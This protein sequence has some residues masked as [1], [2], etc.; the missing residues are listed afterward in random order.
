MPNISIERLREIRELL[1][2]V[3][4]DMT[5]EELSDIGV[6]KPDAAFYA[7]APQIVSDLLSLISELQSQIETLHKQHADLL[8]SEASGSGRTERHGEGWQPIATAPKGWDGT[9]LLLADE[10]GRINRGFWFSSQ[11]DGHW[12]MIGGQWEP[13][14]WMPL[15]APPAPSGASTD[16][17]QQ[18][19][20]KEL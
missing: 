2:R 16:R 1:N 13:T 4:T 14:H 8:G 20:D 10:Q 7:E 15:P 3:N 5:A 6:Y 17:T 9:Q 12:V 19:E 18:R 11:E